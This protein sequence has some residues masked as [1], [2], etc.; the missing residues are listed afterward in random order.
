MTGMRYYKPWRVFIL[1]VIHFLDKSIDL[2]GVTAEKL[3]EYLYPDDMLIDF[4]DRE[5]A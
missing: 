1:L 5:D 3:R 2:M 4:V